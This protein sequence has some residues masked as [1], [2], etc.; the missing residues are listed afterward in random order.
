MSTLPPQLPGTKTRTAPRRALFVPGIRGIIVLLIVA[1]VLLLR[2][3]DLLRPFKIPTASM[4]PAVSAGDHV[5][6]EGIS[7]KFRAPRRGDM[8]VFQAD[9]IPMQPSGTLF[10][11]RVIGEPGD[12]L[13][14]IA[15]KLYVNGKQVT[16]SNE[17][18]PIRFQNVV[19][20]RYLG[21]TNDTFKISA[22]EY[23]VVGD[24][25]RNSADSRHWGAIPAKDIKGRLLLCYWPPK[26]V[27]I[28]R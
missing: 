23:F 9:A 24:N 2:G 12:E 11:K 19:G 25:T 27:G 1:T 6:M 16:L 17:L 21:N 7:Y 8:V 22:G 10:I 13:R 18:G 14:I 15:E 20:A 5:F 28:H 26:R 4:A 3:F